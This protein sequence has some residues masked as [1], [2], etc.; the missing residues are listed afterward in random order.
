MQTYSLDTV[1][2]EDTTLFISVVLMST[3]QLLRL[4][5]YKKNALQRRFVPN[6]L[7]YTRNA[8]TGSISILT[9]SEEHQPL[10]TLKSLKIFS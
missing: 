10:F 4:K 9:I 8:T 1:V 3:E 2:S 7:K 5:P 6:T